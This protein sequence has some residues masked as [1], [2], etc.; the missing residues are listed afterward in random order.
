[1]EES[2]SSWRTWNRGRAR[3][4]GDPSE[5]IA[6]SG[7]SLGLWT[8]DSW[9]S[10]LLLQQGG[11]MPV[12]QW[13]TVINERFL[14]IVFEACVIASLSYLEAMLIVSTGGNSA[15]FITQEADMQAPPLLC[16]RSS[17]SILSVSQGIPFEKNFWGCTTSRLQLCSEV[18]PPRRWCP[19]MDPL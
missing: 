3:V 7:V 5:R 11:R 19:M 15:A 1:M 4:W 6:H 2:M 18:S 14:A 10:R 16:A 8:L 17:P 12:W 13:Y 9:V